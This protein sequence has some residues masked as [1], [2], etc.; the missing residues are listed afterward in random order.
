MFYMLIPHFPP[1]SINCKR[2]TPIYE[3]RHSQKIANY[4]DHAI[5]NFP[6]SETFNLQLFNRHH[7]FYKLVSIV[8]NLWSLEENEVSKCRG[9]NFANAFVDYVTIKTGFEIVTSNTK[10]D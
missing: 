3:N 7:F 9:E 2:L 6:P 8:V 1:Q 5:G 4:K 10:P